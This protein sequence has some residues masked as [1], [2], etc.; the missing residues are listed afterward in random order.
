MK[1]HD[2]WRNQNYC[3]P[4]PFLSVQGTNV[5]WNQSLNTECMCTTMLHSHNKTWM[6]GAC[7]MQYKI[8]ATRC[9]S[10]AC[11]PQCYFLQ[12]CLGISA[13]S[14]WDLIF[15]ALSTGK[16]MSGQK[17]IHQMTSKKVWFTAHFMHHVKA[18]I[19]FEVQS[20]TWSHLIRGLVSHMFKWRLMEVWVWV[21]VTVD[22]HATTDWHIWAQMKKT[23][24]W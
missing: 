18:P 17:A 3:H 15:F 5:C 6:Q 9:R 23:Q 12:Q 16:I 10:S 21:M 22:G 8:I 2:F 7:A 19:H 24:N 1:W 11:A 14:Y 20:Q 4:P 13:A